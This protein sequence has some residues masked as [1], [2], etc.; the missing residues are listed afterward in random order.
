VPWITKQICGTDKHFIT[1][2]WLYIDNQLD[3]FIS[4]I[5]GHYE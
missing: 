4:Y 2:D 1:P 3:I 5:S